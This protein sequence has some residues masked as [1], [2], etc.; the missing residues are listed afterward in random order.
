MNHQIFFYVN[1][2][3]KHTLVYFVMIKPKQ[4]KTFAYMVISLSFR[5]FS[6]AAICLLQQS[7]ILGKPRGSRLSHRKSWNILPSINKLLFNIFKMFIYLHTVHINL[8]HLQLFQKELVHF[9]MIRTKSSRQDLMLHPVNFDKLFF[10]I[11]K[12]GGGIIS[13]G[14]NITCNTGSITKSAQTHTIRTGYIYGLGCRTHFL[15]YMY[16]LT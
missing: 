11:V 1:Q 3:N 15:G 7:Q 12:S 14:T 8:K 4:T 13:Y 9:V 5:F 6:F 10:F 2:I 16:Q